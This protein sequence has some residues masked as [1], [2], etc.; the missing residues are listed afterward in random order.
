MYVL[1]ALALLVPQDKKT[2]WA[3]LGARLVNADGKGARV[4]AVDEKSAA[5]DAGL[6]PGDVITEFDGKKIASAE[7]LL[8]Q[9]WAMELG[10]TV[11]LRAGD[12]EVE[13]K[14]ATIKGQAIPGLN[15]IVHHPPA[16]RGIRLD[17]PEKGDGY[18]TRYVFDLVVSCE[19]DVDEEEEA[20]LKAL[21]EKSAAIWFDTTEGQMR[22]RRIDYY[23][24]KQKWDACH[25]RLRKTRGGG[26]VGIEHVTPGGICS[27]NYG[28]ALDSDTA[29]IIWNHEAGHMQLGSGDEYKYKPSDPEP[30]PCVMGD[31]C[32]KG[33]QDLCSDDDHDYRMKES[34]WRN[35]A[36]WYPDATYEADPK[37]AH[38]KLTKT[39][40]VVFHPNE[41]AA[42]KKR[43]MDD[44]KKRLDAWR[45]R[46]L[47]EIEKVLDEELKP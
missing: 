12:R 20:R 13:V 41:G 8:A 38:P 42:L 32:F 40:D 44:V 19:W 23:E 28:V 4:E 16:I 2:G 34:C 25:Y 1:I 35:V 36:R 26:A 27:L 24:S 31:D 17:A 3:D 9:L 46:M 21:A 6:K 29:A 11:K 33:N 39:P 43:I 14:P 47:E 10:R 37:K 30:C 5:A 18:T 7:A 22:W 15:N 45:G